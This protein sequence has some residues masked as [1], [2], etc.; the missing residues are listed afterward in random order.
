MTGRALHVA[1]SLLLHGRAWLIRI[2]AKYTAVSAFVGMGHGT[3]LTGV[4]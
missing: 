3:R 4:G 1:Y 2:G